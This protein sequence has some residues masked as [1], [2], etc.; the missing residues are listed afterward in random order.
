MCH[1]QRSKNRRV[2]GE[3][4]TEKPTE[5]DVSG[6]GEAGVKKSENVYIV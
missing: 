3:D 4:G 2:G 6:G 5:V 1:I